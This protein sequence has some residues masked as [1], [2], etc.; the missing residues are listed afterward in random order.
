[1]ATGWPMKTTYANG[2]VYSSQD[3]NDITGTINLLTST[4]LSSSAGKNGVING[5]MDIW[6]RGTSFNSV[7][8]S[9]TNYTADRWIN[10]NTGTTNCNV[11]RQNTSD[12]TN[13]PTIQYC[14]RVSRASGNTNTS[15][16]WMAQALETSASY[17]FI[18]KTAVYSFY[19]RR[20]A[21]YS[22][23]ANALAVTVG[24]GTGTDQGVNTGALANVAFSG[25]A[26][27]T[28]TWQRFTFTGTIPTN[29]TQVAH[30]V[31]YT[32]TGTAGAN[33][34]YEITGV[35]LELGSYATTFSRAGGTIQGELAACQRYYYRQ[36]ASTAYMPFT[37][38]LSA[39]TTS[40][41]VVQ[42]PLPV[43]MRV[44]PTSLEYAN[45]I[46]TDQLNNVAGGVALSLDSQNSK[47]IGGIFT[48]GGGGA[49]TIYRP[50]QLI[51]NNNTS[52]YL[53]FNA[54]L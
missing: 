15:G 43:Q 39:Y 40:S 16:L 17:P 34:Y 49:F 18:G 37:S 38:N 54:E 50:Y 2:D 35:Q 52:A 10:Y 41:I 8:T 9:G 5:G 13:L 26:T 36:T 19:A 23:T 44:T 21:N 28:T 20:G 29:A 31:A 14:A 48:S 30:Y 25:T 3:V 47:Y 46:F 12:T 22:A 27:L 53:A 4:T 7:G 33:D 42:L 51:A 45:L 32:P 6:Q 1:M 11:T 24:Y